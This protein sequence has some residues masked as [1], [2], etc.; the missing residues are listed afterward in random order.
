M[1]KKWQNFLNRWVEAGFILPSAAERIQEFEATREKQSGG[2]GAAVVIIA[3]VF[4]GVLLGA[5]VLLFV[6]SHWDRISPGERFALVLFQVAVFHAAGAALASRSQALAT[7]LHAVGTVALGGGIFLTGQI[8]HLQEHWPNG[9]LLWAVGAWVG[10]ALLRDWPQALAAALLTPIWLY[11]EWVV[12]SES[13]G[14]FGPYRLVD[15][16]LLMLAIAYFTALQ[17]G[18]DSSLRRAL[19]WTGG[20]MLFPMVFLAAQSRYLDWIYWPREIPGSLMLFG[21]FVALAGP[22]AVAFLLRRR[23]AWYNLV[24]AAWVLLLRTATVKSDEENFF[25][26]AWEELGSYFLYGLASAGMIWWGVKEKRPER[27][28]MGLAGFGLTVMEFYFSSV[29]DKLGRSTSLMGL[30]LLF[31]VV[32]WGLDRARRRLMA[33]LE[34]EQGATS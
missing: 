34:D 28:Y 19:T 21:G 6:A 12:V 10:W 8:F 33:K 30:G 27:V 31:L 29:M 26:F 7:V 16:G 13:V 2:R 11:S 1:A 9:V 25:V 14:W 5:G 15:D 3:W 32:G 4:G 22:L 17:P 18:R 23:A 24:A 20:I